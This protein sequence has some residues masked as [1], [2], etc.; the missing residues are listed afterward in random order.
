[1]KDRVNRHLLLNMR[2]LS[3]DFSYVKQW[4]KATL[5]REHD[6]RPISPRMYLLPWRAEVRSRHILTD[7][8][9]VVP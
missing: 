8:R 1:M 2:L 3:M 6:D 9:E 7:D 4:H 5:G